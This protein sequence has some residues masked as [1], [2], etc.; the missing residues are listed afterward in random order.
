M[1]RK[2]IPVT[3][4]VK[5]YQGVDILIYEFLEEVDGSKEFLDMPMPKMG[6][7]LRIPLEK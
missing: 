3:G 6:R 1:L 4:N 7:R 5:S 2:T